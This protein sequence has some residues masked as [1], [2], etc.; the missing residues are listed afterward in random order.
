MDNVIY[1]KTDKLIQEYPKHAG[2]GSVKK[3]KRITSHVHIEEHQISALLLHE[4]APVVLVK[5]LSQRKKKSRTISEVFY[6][7]LPQL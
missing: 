3:I 6:S 4:G 5:V 1:R 7:Y 2:H